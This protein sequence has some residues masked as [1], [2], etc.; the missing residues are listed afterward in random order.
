MDFKEF[1]KLL[2]RL[3][4]EA[5]DPPRRRIRSVPRPQQELNDALLRVRSHILSYYQ[6]DLEQV[7]LTGLY[8]YAARRLLRDCIVH[9]EDIAKDFQEY[10][11]QYAV[12]SERWRDQ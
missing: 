9:P 10:R 8:E 11:T 2:E 3:R 5:K 1:D 7:T 12:W 4:R 6:P